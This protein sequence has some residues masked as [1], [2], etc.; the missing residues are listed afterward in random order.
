MLDKPS[1]IGGS[2]PR[3]SRRSCCAARSMSPDDISTSGGSPTQG[4]QRGGERRP[5]RRRER[6]LPGPPTPVERVREV[7]EA[8]EP[9][10]PKSTS[11]SKVPTGLVF[12]PSVGPAAPRRGAPGRAVVKI[13]TRKGDDGT[14]GLWYGGRVSK[15][16][17]RPEAYGAVDEAASALGLAARGG[18]CPGR[19]CRR[20]P[21]APARAV[22]GGA[23]LATSAGAGPTAWRR[24][25]PGSPSTWSIAWRGG[26]SLHG[27]G[28]P[29]AQVRHPGEA[30]CPPA[31]TLPGPPLR[32]ERRWWT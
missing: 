22:R 17:P 15:S 12:N 24:V 13:Y 32:R 5:R 27:A 11:S 25:C 28:R 20:H 2:T 14:T 23:E 18:G 10:P 1:R 31:S 19:R 21:G 6:G 30:S 29:S 9:M 26:R 16:D 8:G 7:A 3:C 4:R